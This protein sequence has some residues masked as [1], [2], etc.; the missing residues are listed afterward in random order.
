L[1]LALTTAR[2]HELR[3]VDQPSRQR[4][5]MAR[6]DP[7]RWYPLHRRMIDAA[8]FMLTSRREREHQRQAL[9]TVRERFDVQCGPLPT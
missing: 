1:P 6:I 9:D 4:I 2:E 3:H 8:Q 7:A 5:P